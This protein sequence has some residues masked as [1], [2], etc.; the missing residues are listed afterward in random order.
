MFKY[1]TVLASALFSYTV[2]AESSNLEFLQALKPCAEKVHAAMQN[3]SNGV[4]KEDLDKCYTE[5][6]KSAPNINRDVAMLLIG[7]SA[8]DLSQINN[9]I[10]THKS[11][12]GLKEVSAT[13]LVNEFKN[14]ELQ[15]N[16]IYKGKEFII[17]GQ[18]HSIKESMGNIVLSLKADEFGFETVDCIVLPEEKE[19]V[20]K[21]KKNQKIKVK[22]TITGIM[23]VSVQV[24]DTIL[25]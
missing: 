11:A 19:K 24:K 4:L 3:Q 18:I 7:Y 5:I 15:A 13:N 10:T 21:L 6:K 12:Q 8:Y 20:I 23:I 25:L 22:G 17:T 9:K 2:S 14:N 16:E 1:L